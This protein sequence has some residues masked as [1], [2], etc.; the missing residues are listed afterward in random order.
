MKMLKINFISFHSFFSSLV[1]FLFEK[2]R[3]FFDDS[4]ETNSRIFKDMER[5]ICLF[6]G[7]SRK[8]KDLTKIQGLSRFFKVRGHRCTQRPN[9][10]LIN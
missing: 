6:Q 2:A 5:K 1:T 7:S 3:F 4:K 9:S 10:T 8:F